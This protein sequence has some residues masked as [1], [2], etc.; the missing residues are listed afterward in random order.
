MGQRAWSRNIFQ[1]FK[2][3][4]IPR[5]LVGLLFSVGAWCFI[6]AFYLLVRAYGSADTFDWMTGPVSIILM[7]FVM[8][9]LLG[10]LDWG[11]SSLIDHSQLRTKPFWAL[12]LIK[13]SCLIIALFVL[14]FLARLVAVASGKLLLSELPKAYLEHISNKRFV[15]SIVY[16]AVSAMIMAFIRQAAAM[17]GPRILL[18]LMTGR[19]HRPRE[20]ELI[21]MFLDMKASTRLAERLGHRKFSLL[22][23]D[24]FRDLTNVAI[25]HRVEIYK[26]VGDEA[27]LTWN[28]RD[29]LYDCNCLRVFFGFCEVLEKRRDYYESAYDCFPEFKAGLNLGL[30]TVAEIGVLKREIAYL[31]DVLNTAA[32][33]Q[34]HCNELARPILLS[35]SLHDR[36]PSES[37]FTFHSE[38]EIALRG[39]EEKVALFSVEYN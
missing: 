20:E 19:Y 32:R 5:P 21:F 16:V 37:P 9:V 29:G 39:R 11:A 26:Y 33:I 34:G 14:I 31:S 6:G 2:E 38:G 15:V 12:L 18:N 3:R 28:P 23:Q 27:I 7:V 4:R 10:S 25:K 36:L 8:G 13:S 1:P 24:C 35:G 22:L 17:V 30:V